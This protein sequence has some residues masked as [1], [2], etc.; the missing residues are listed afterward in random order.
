MKRSRFWLITGVTVAAVVIIIVI[1]CLAQCA[2]SGSTPLNEP[3]IPTVDVS[4]DM[5]NVPTHTP[6]PS[7]TPMTEPVSAYRLPLAPIWDEDT[8]TPTVS[9]A[10]SNS[11]IIFRE[12]IKGQYSSSTKDFM[13]VGTEDGVATAIFLVR[14]EGT[15]LSIIAI[16]Y[17]ALASV[18]TLDDECKIVS[19]QYT[20]LGEATRLGGTNKTQRYWNL[21]WAVKNLVGVQV[22]HYLCIELECLDA[23]LDAVGSFE[24]TNA[25]YTS[26][27]IAPY[28]GTTREQKTYV[29]M[30][31][32]VGLLKR[33]REMSLWELPS[34]QKATKGC[35]HSSLGAMDLIPMARSLQGVTSISCYTIP[36]VYSDGDYRLDTQQA[37]DILQKV[38]GD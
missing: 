8:P 6:A 23:V 33:L 16:P 28:L 4:P 34:M 31:I 17:E 38:Y 2:A 19:T 12:P 37:K 10:V 18:Y 27:N 25:T 1:I 22:S 15:Q 3:I 20:R 29:M 36:L 13:A 24:G 21:I 11:P 14:L 30:D 32:G 7:S 5:T 35:V 26:A 9:P